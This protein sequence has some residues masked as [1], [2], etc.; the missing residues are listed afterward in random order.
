MRKQWIA[1]TIAII[2]AVLLV[3]PGISSAT[4][5]YWSHGYGPKSKSIAGAC[6]A[7]AF[8]AMC[9]ASNPG[10]LVIVGNRMEAGFALFT[11][12]R[13]FNADDNASPVGPPTGPASI[14]PGHYESS[15]NWFLIPHFAYNRMLDENTSLGI[16]VG[17][18]GGMNTEYNKAVFAN[19]GN[20]MMP[21]TV[22]TSPTGIN[23]MQG[24]VAFPFSKKL[25][26]QH[27]IG[28]APILA[29]QSFEAKGLQ[30]FTSFSIHPE[31]VTNNGR[32]MSYGG[33]VRI[34]W[35]GQ[36]TPELNLG[37]SYQTK[38]WMSK[39][40]KYKGLFAEE[41]GFDI[42]SNYDLGFSYKITPAFTFAFD[43]Q[44]IEFKKIKTISNPA[45]LVFMPGSTLLGTSEGLGFGW[46]NMSV[47]KMGAQWE[48]NPEWSF[49]VGF[50]YA[51]KAI[52]PSQTLFNVLAPATVTKHYTL[53][54]TK[55]MDAKNEI[56][57]AVMYAPQESISGTNPNTGPQTG[58][59][60]MDQWEI[61]I[62]WAM[63]F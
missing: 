16:T 6:V 18:N 42:P 60:Y 58:N 61:E 4:N 11:P 28:I 2:T 7:M 36:I 59:I 19:F 56:S 37:A 41:G 15:N 53:G 43:Y 14:D 51:D 26:A 32:D 40:D 48:Y 27:S 22:A 47:Y 49:R 9:T 17:G 13:G 39:F 33:G 34:G 1:I 12:N 25:N 38:M 44:R 10:S 30:P 54:F 8:G 23:L 46:K 62:G 31:A 29:I 24:F 50:S 45:N 52:E 5:G 55:K 21:S 63:R 35:L 3:L 57:T 20:P